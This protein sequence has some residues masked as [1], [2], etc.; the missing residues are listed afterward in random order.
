MR[1]FL[2]LCITLMLFSAY[3]I[4]QTRTI[5]G[6]VLDESGQPLSNVSVVVRGSKIGT[7]T[8]QNGT[9]SLSVPTTATHLIFSSIGRQATE[10]AIDNRSVIN[11]T[12]R[13]VSSELAEVVV[14]GY[15]TATKEAFTGSA[16]VV[17][18]ADISKKMY[19]M[20]RKLWLVKFRE[21]R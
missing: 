13:L 1:K 9:Y 17:S 3:A 14:T 21:F 20:Y 8:N 7:T 11:I 2:M 18:S 19:L 5:T 4:S 12:L 10:A 6:T 15:T 16:K